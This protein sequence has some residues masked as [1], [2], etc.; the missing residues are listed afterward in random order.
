[1]KIASHH[2]KGTKDHELSQIIR[3]TPDYTPQ[4][5]WPEDC[6]V[7]WGQG[8]IPNTPFFE[9]FMPGN[10][11]RGEGADIAE[12]EAKAFA[13]YEKEG[14]CNHSWGRQRPGRQFYTNGAGWCKKCGAFRS[15][16]F[17][18]LF[19]IGSYRKPLSVMEAGF[20]E[21]METDHEM[22]EHMDKTYP[23]ERESTRKYRRKLEIRRK[24]FGVKNSY[25]D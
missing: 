21:D 19:I 2:I 5:A 11:I 15:N 20:L 4:K 25:G 14:L 13:Q 1:M 10:F 23:E 3:K 24:L 8:I 7:Q 16:M 9:A 18:E 17:K 12:A 22:N 6:T